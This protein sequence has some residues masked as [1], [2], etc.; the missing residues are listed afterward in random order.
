MAEEI[1]IKKIENMMFAS[2]GIVPHFYTEGY[3]MIPLH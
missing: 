3:R 1:Y 2:I